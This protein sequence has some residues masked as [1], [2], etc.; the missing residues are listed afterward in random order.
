MGLRAQGR[1]LGI[2]PLLALAVYL[3][4]DQKLGWADRVVD[5]RT[6]HGGG[7]HVSVQEVSLYRGH[8]LK[9]N[10]RVY[11]LILMNLQNLRGT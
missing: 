3:Y 8:S 7:G 1:V 10:S 2:S 9:V 11:L 5:V 4:D 6:S